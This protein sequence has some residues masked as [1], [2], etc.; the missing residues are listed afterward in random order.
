MLSVMSPTI[1][2]TGAALAVEALKD[3]S[4]TNIFGYPGACVLSIYNELA[5]T[6][7]ITHCLCRHE[8]ACVHAAEGYARVSGKTGI[9][10]VTSGPGAT[11]TVTG[12]ANA[13]ADSIPILVIAGTP[14]N[15]CGKSFQNVKFEEMVKT[16]TKNCYKPNVND[17]IYNVVKNAAAE[18]TSGK[19]GPVLVQLSRAV[20]EKKYEYKKNI[21]NNKFSIQTNNLDI[22]KIA[23]KINK[24]NNPVF[25]IGGGCADAF[26][27]LSKLI[28]ETN[29]PAVSTLMGVGNVSENIGSYCGMIG[30]NGSERANKTLL[31]ADLIVAFGVAFSDRTTCKTNMF[32]D[33]TPVINI[34]IEP[35]KFKNVNVV[36]ELTADCKD[37]ISSLYN[38]GLIK[39][40]IIKYND[41]KIF[42]PAKSRKMLTNEVLAEINTFTKCFNPIIIT[43]VGQHQMLAAK[44]FEF[45][46]PKHFLTSGGMG[47]MGFGLPAACGAHFA[48]PEE[49]I[50]NIT[51]DGSFQMNIQELATV[52][53][54]NIPIKIFV[55]NNGYL[56]MIKQIQEKLYNGKYYQSKMCNPDFIKLAEGYGIKGIR[57]K[58]IHTLKAALPDIFMTNEPIVVDCITSEDEL[59]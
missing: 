41:K 2:K 37:V 8:Q 13:F 50:I 53:E 51:G 29:V 5:E 6:P 25:L 35:Y 30:I 52:R 10:L 11:N 33:G 39:R 57:I 36:E 48:M 43:D 59:V 19:K 3:S 20:L 32:A 24:A 31:S 46:K 47:T 9:V 4:V 45:N 23:E 42:Q 56:G 49:V 1:Y 27:E 12:I 28:K 58:N 17:D 26:F 21:N 55:M 34:N 38:Y 15:Y 7:E 54:Y 40:Q 16:V 22:K 44:C 18:S 14:S